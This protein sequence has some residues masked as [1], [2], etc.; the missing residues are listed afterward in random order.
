MKKIEIVHTEFNPFEYLTDFC[1]ELTTAKNGACNL[2][3]GSMRD[4]NE[5]D[6]VLSMQ[7]EYY[8]GMTEKALV[9]MVDYALQEWQINDVLLVHRVGKIDL[10]ESIVLVGVWASHRADSFSACRYLIDELKKTA[11]FW[12]KEQLQDG[13]R[14][15]G[16]NT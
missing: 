12:K 7:L 6:S 2:F 5:G 4:F 15:V 9:Q 11:P 13:S 1:N 14:W 8:P 3:I 16:K 10:K